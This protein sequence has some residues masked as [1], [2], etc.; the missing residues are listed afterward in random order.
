[1]TSDLACR[2]CGEDDPEFLEAAIG[3]TT[4]L[5][6][7]RGCRTTNRFERPSTC[8]CCGLVIPQHA[9]HCPKALR[10]AV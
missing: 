4:V 9:D 6:Y 2:F 7:C 5:I 3:T 10:W 1:M 8:A